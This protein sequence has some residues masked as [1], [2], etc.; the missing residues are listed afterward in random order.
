MHTASEVT[1]SEIAC[2]INSDIALK[3]ICEKKN[4]EVY[5]TRCHDVP[6]EHLMAKEKKIV[7]WKMLDHLKS[8]IKDMF[9][10]EG[11]P[12]SV[13]SDYL[14]YQ[15]WDTCQAFCSSIS[16]I[17]SMSAVMQ[18]VGVGSNTASPV[19]AAITWI[20]KDGTGMVGSIVFAWLKG[21]QLDS[22]C[23]KWRLF[24][25]ILND[26]AMCLELYL[27]CALN[28][29]VY[30]LCLS[31]AMKA[32]VGVAGSATRAAVSCHQAI[33]G[34][35]ADVAA[36]DGSQEIFVNL[37]AY[38]FG[39][40][41]LKNVTETEYTWYVMCTFI[42]LHLFCNYKAVSCLRINVYNGERYRLSLRSFLATSD[43]PTVEQVNR[44][45]SI[46]LGSGVSDKKIFGF[47]IHLGESLQESVLNQNLSEEDIVFIASLFQTKNYLVVPDVR[48]KEMLVS[49]RKNCAG[50]DILKGY[51]HAV[52]TAAAVGLA[53]ENALPFVKRRRNNSPVSRLQKAIKEY[54][55]DK[56]ID[57]HK[58]EVLPV[59][60]LLGCLE[61][62]ER[63]FALF[64]KLSAQQGWNLD[65]TLIPVGDWRAV[66]RHEEEK[67]LSQNS[68]QYKKKV[69][70]NSS[71]SAS[72]KGKKPSHHPNLRQYVNFVPTYPQM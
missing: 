59:V 51:F 72:A 28:Y 8:L 16:G 13:S 9:L 24:A 23:K 64:C 43:V 4:L 10:P 48:K 35:T 14:E 71:H 30:L 53:M 50:T 25:D 32:L 44:N 20:V 62:V 18:G 39:I 19:S 3:E 55:S 1:Q 37:L 2:V 49:F 29:S 33:Q 63:E 54:A 12:D 69:T 40:F 11:Y 17:L 61:V 6:S 47:D 22:D 52:L 21:S 56:K 31:T 65:K 7:S 41:L 26:A 5:F 45:E 67:Q 46:I 68:L 15:I 36:K 38:I 57:V 60:A 42:F 58:S 27:P 70:Y 66:W 34:N